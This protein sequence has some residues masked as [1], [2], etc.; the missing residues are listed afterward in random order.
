MED[1]YFDH[2]KQVISILKDNGLDEET[3]NEFINKINRKCIKGNFGDLVKMEIH[4]KLKENYNILKA[5]DYDFFSKNELDLGEE[6]INIFAKEHWDNMSLDDK[7]KIFR[8]LSKMFNL[9]RK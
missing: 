3:H 1:P 6:K 9:G 7:K 8:L 5:K 4:S 2:L